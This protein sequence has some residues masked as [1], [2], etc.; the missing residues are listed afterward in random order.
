MK[1]KIKKEKKYTWAPLICGRGR[2]RA[3]ITSGTLQWSGKAQKGKSRM[4][5]CSF[6]IPNSA[7]KKIETWPSRLVV[8][9]SNHLQPRS[10]TKALGKATGSATKGQKANFPPT[11]CYK[12]W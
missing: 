5:N 9:W 8:H 11:F 6:E 2:E 10:Q 1:R 7:L 4:G 12:W 3:P